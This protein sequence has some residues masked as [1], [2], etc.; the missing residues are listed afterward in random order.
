MN[1]SLYLFLQFS[2]GTGG[3]F[4]RYKAGTVDGETESLDDEDGK[5]DEEVTVVLTCSIFCSLFEYIL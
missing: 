1:L 4:G 3:G 5:E 2:P